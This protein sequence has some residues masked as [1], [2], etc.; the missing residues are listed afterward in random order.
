MKKGFETLQLFKQLT[1]IFQGMK[2][3]TIIVAL[4]LAST[5][6]IAKAKDPFGYIQYCG[7]FAKE[8]RRD[9]WKD[10]MNGRGHI[11]GS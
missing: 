10:H 3:T 8:L 2:F 9:C 6:V 7:G 4:T 5:E 1:L 11:W